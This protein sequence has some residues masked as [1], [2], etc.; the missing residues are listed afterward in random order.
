MPLNILQ[1]L[2]LGSLCRLHTEYC[3]SSLEITK[4]LLVEILYLAAT[5]LPWTVCHIGEV[6]NVEYYIL[7]GPFKVNINK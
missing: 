7:I 5:E 6:F 2:V 1:P 4:G 3:V